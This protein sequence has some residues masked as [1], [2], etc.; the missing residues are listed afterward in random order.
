MLS[1]INKDF[2][3]IIIYESATL[4]YIPLIINI[5][6]YVILKRQ[7]IVSDRSGVIVVVNHDYL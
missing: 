6:F 3:I 4:I 7:K 5:S 1:S 2:I